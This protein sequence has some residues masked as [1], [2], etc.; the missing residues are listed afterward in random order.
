[1]L[2]FGL[3]SVFAQA[4][5]GMA[6]LSRADALRVAGELSAAEGLYREGLAIFD[7]STHDR[8]RY[9]RIC[10]DGLESIQYVRISFPF[11]EEEMNAELAKAYPAWVAAGG[12]ARTAAR[13]LESFVI[14]GKTM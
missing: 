3:T 5:G 10:R 12:N 9:A 4:E 2:A 11:D 7:T 8:A 1:M 6:L 14:D 13:G